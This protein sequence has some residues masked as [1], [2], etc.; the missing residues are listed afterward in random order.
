MGWRD[1]LLVL[2]GIMLG[3]V[4]FSGSDHMF[5]RHKVH[6]PPANKVHAVATIQTGLS[7]TSCPGGDPFVC[8]EC[9]VQLPVSPRLSL[10]TIKTMWG[11]SP[12][13]KMTY[14]SQ[15][16]M[17][18]LNKLNIFFRK[19]GNWLAVGMDSYGL[20]FPQ[21]VLALN[22]GG[23]SVFYS[24]TR[25]ATYHWAHQSRNCNASNTDLTLRDVFTKLRWDMVFLG[26]DAPPE[27]NELVK[28]WWARS[29]TESPGRALFVLNEEKGQAAG[30]ADEP[31]V[32][33]K[34]TLIYG[35]GYTA[36]SVE[37]LLGSGTTPER[38]QRDAVST[39]YATDRSKNSGNVQY[40]FQFDV[41]EEGDAYW[42]RRHKP[43]YADVKAWLFAE[44]DPY[45]LT[46]F[47]GIVREADKGNEE[48]STRALSGAVYSLLLPKLKPRMI[49]ELGVFRGG[50]TA[51]AVQILR[52]LGLTDSFVVCVDTWLNDFCL[53]FEENTHK[54][55]ESDYCNF[56]NAQ[57]ASLMY[58]AFLRKMTKENMQSQVIPLPSAV[59]VA[60]HVFTE[61]GWTPDLIFV[62]AS[63]AFA[64]V[65]LDMEN[66]W[67]LL[68][69]G[70]VMAGD[71]FM[72]TG[73]QQAVGTFA[74]KRGLTI[75]TYAGVSTKYWILP[76]KECAP[77]D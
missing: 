11:Q 50:S 19:R 20:G 29:E 39:G 58:Y 74:F 36:M 15:N 38:R 10:Q 28:Q 51:K 66:W 8:K 12:E 64:D 18:S 33:S 62:D 21:Q 37:Q 1:I 77:R 52:K 57:G 7:E 30:I 72:T 49:V 25:G 54:N 48:I 44:R 65:L 53:Q 9:R 26:Q 59:T 63:H 45:N 55:T 67:F 56:P 71:D 27:T 42:G 70:G 68:A 17:F 60:A 6:R 47:P 5:P 41:S 14:M 75:D 43:M 2:F 73:V 69:C 32:K 24:P 40:T 13:P 46:A 31:L 76:P 34:H 22:D 4:I 16:D 35:Q 3:S 23:R 61:A